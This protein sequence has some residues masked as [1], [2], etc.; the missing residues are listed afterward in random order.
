LVVQGSSTPTVT[1]GTGVTDH[2][3]GDAFSLN[4]FP[5]ASTF[6]PNP[7]QL[8]TN[9]FITVTGDAG[10]PTPTPLPS[11]LILLLTGMLGVG[12]FAARH[13]FAGHGELAQ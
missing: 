11:S 3:D 7:L 2:G 12:L 1:V 4:A 5:P 9:V 10:A 6:I 8:P 13:K